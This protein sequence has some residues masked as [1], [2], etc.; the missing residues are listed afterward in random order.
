[1]AGAAKSLA[2][3]AGRASLPEQ[4]SFR[5]F[6]RFSLFEYLGVCALAAT[7]FILTFAY[8]QTDADFSGLI[9]GEVNAGLLQA[10]LYLEDSGEVSFHDSLILFA[11]RG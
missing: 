3:V 7:N 11:Q 4:P 9:V 10:F 2:V 6:A 8:L 5:C 1:M